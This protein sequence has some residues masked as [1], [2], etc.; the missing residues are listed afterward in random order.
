MSV[1]ASSSSGVRWCEFFE[2][3]LS[4]VVILVVDVFPVPL[5]VMSEVPEGWFVAASEPI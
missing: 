1:P 3:A 4:F 2:V 5:L